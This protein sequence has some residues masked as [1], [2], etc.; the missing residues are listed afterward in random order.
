MANEHQLVAKVHYP[1]D[2][3]PIWASGHASAGVSL[4][5]SLPGVANKTTYLLKAIITT[6]APAT[7]QNME[8]TI[9]D[10]AT[11]GYLEMVQSTAGG[12]CLM[13]DLGD[14]PIPANAPNTAITVTIPTVASGAIPGLILVGYQR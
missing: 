5:V 1:Q 11:T 3:T 13:V 7:Q 8:V 10:G 12:G 4:A 9:F 2:A 6:Q 14:A